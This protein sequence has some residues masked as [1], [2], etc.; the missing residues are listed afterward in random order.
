MSVIHCYRGRRRNLGLELYP[1]GFPGI[2]RMNRVPNERI[3]EKGVDER[4][5]KGILLWF[6]HVKRIDKDRIAKR[7]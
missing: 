2:R 7:F 1:Q 6:G 3:R 4:I 5:D